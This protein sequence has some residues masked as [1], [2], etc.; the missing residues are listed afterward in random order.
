MEQV[1][2]DSIESYE[3][4]QRRL[5]HLLRKEGSEGTAVALAEAL[6]PGQGQELNVRHLRACVYTDAG[7]KLK[8]P[9][10]V[11]EGVRIWCEMKPHDSVT[12]SYNLASAQ[13][14]LWQLAVEQAGLGDAWLNERSQLHEA[15]RLFNLVA[16]HKDA[17]TE[18]RLKALTDCGNSF[19]NIGRYLDALDCYERALKLDSSFGMA[20]G[21][22]GITFLNVA[23]LMGGHESHVQSQAVSDLDIAISDQDRVLRCGGQSAL[24]TFKRRRSG[25]LVTEDSHHNPHRRRLCALPPSEYPGPNLLPNSARDRRRWPSASL[26][27]LRSWA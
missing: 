2:I 16:Q 5:S 23:S 8:D 27:L 14:H 15:R 17:D 3:R 13:L 9:T 1:V 21:N 11:Q 10:L 4:T 6:V 7:I 20:A 19:D 18:L 26:S 24:E 12:I 22:R 25:L